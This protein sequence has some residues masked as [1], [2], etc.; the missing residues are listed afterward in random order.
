MVDLRTAPSGRVS[1][2]EER[3]AEL[4]LIC[5]DVTVFVAAMEQRGLKPAGSEPGLGI[6]DEG[7]AAGGGTLGVY[8][9]RHQ[10]PK[11]PGLT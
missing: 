10:R 1:I 11:Q 4:Y 8:E 5:E 7:H 2:G 6:G 9:P 3:R